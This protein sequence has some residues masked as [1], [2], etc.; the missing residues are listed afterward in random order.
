M[1]ALASALGALERATQTDGDPTMA[2][3]DAVEV[4]GKIAERTAAEGAL[5]ALRRRQLVS[6]GARILSAIIRRGV[7]SGT[8]RPPCVRWAVGSLPY[9]IVAG[10]CARSVFDLREE[11]SLRAGAAADA[12]LEVLRPRVLATR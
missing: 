11:R 2:L 5:D 6:Q 12:A 3:Y 7:E 10:V 9:A 4:I 8:F 1:R